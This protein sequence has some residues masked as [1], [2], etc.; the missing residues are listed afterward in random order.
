MATNQELTNQLVALTDSNNKLAQRLDL[1]EA[2]LVRQKSLVAAAQGHG[3]Q[4][5][6][7]GVFDKKRLYPKELKEHTVFRTWAERFIAWMAMDSRN[8]AT[9]FE[10]ATKVKEFI[11][12]PVDESQKAYS[13]A[14]YGH[15]R[16]LTEGH[17]KAAKIVANVRGDNGLECWRR[18]SRK[19]DPQNA[20]VHANKLQSII[21]LGAQNRVK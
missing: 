7:A 5:G 2:E 16:M 20:T 9:G 4:G 3:G 17:K 11:E 15:L 21:L 6:G 14:I 18:L 1:A 12:P 13:E 8:V 19:F 10:R